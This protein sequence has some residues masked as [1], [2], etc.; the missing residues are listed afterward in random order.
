MD[1]RTDNPFWLLK[2]GFMEVYPSL[3]KDFSTEYAIVGGGI[4]GALIAWHLA[5]AGIETAVFD[6]RHIGMGS[7]CASTS[8]LQY[9]IDTPLFELAEMVG[10]K[11]AARSYQ[12]CIRAIDEIEKICKKLKVKTDFERKPS[13]Y[14]ASLKKDFPEILEK[15]FSIRRKHKIN[16]ELWD[17]KELADKFP[18]EN[19]GALYSPKDAAQLDV[20]R[21]THG[22]LQDAKN[23]GAKVYDKTEI[24]KIEYKK[25][26]VVLKTKDGFEIKAKKII[27]ACGYESVNYLPENLVR[28]HS[29]YALASEPF[30]AK[31]LWYKNCLIWE[32]AQPYLY[33]RTTADNR[34]I[35]GGKDE[36]F[37]SP[38]K[39]DKLLARKTREIVESFK[40]KF[41]KINLVPDYYWAGTFG[42]TEDGLPYIGSIK[43]V[44]HTIFALGF[45]GNGITFSQ[46]AAE[47]IRDE[48]TGIKNKDAKIFSFDRSK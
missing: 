2:N 31:N 17:E 12:L 18:F 34:I 11:N 45:G 3:K 10:E 35:V 28:L 39:R 7:T 21:M 29:T 8:L 32:T 16:V 19:A 27:I 36:P 23:S 43:Q 5:K 38:N 24:E 44:P 25:R 6:R 40:A 1:I 15:E 22:L 48:A 4:T 9:E 14:L 30:D 20:Y 41:P 46:I 47:I 42:E 26:G 13:I 33:M 37:Q